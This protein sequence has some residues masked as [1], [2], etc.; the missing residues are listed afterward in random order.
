M[1][2]GDVWICIS[3]QKIQCSKILYTGKCTMY[4]HVMR[5]SVKKMCIFDVIL[6][7]F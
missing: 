4:V 3:D 7:T 1:F 5:L 6:S 2:F